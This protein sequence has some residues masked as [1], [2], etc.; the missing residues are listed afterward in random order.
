MT[1]AVAAV[2]AATAFTAFTAFTATTRQMAKVTNMG[3]KK[4]DRIKSFGI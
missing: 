2:A 4:I 1:T 3:Y